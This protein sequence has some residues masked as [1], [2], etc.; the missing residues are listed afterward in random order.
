MRMQHTYMNDIQ[1]TQYDAHAAHIH[2]QP[3]TYT[4]PSSYITK[5]FAVGWTSHISRVE[6]AILNWLIFVQIMNAYSN[7]CIAG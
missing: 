6:T 7:T 1:H 5:L 2:E 4:G 3:T